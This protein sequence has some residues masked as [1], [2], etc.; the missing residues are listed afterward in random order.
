MTE[1][2]FALREFCEVYSLKTLIGF[3]RE[4]GLKFH[5]NVLALPV[6]SDFDH[7]SLETTFSDI[8][9]VNVVKW[10]DEAYLSR[11]RPYGFT[12]DKCHEWDG[13]MRMQFSS[14]EIASCKLHSRRA[15]SHSDGPL[16][17]A[18]N[19]KVESPV[20][21]FQVGI[22]GRLASLPYEVIVVPRHPL[23]SQAMENVVIPDSIRFVNTMGELE[24]L[25]AEAD[26]TIM[27]RILS[28]DGLR[29]D[30]D[31]NP[32][33]ATINSNTLCGVISEIP[34]PYE[35]LYGDSG[36][37]HQ[38]ST[39]NSMY[40]GINRWIR[41][42]D[43]QVKLFRRDEWVRSNRKRYLRRIIEVLETRSGE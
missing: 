23:S 26:L 39:L 43:L 12:T 29:P 10:F 25:H 31:H 1:I 33:E 36:L 28:R 3:C 15:R 8:P 20:E 27:G 35:W 7:C 37:I 17:V 5:L 11:S 30:D 41:D 24:S 2:T 4:L 13:Y 21:D 34:A 6:N 32:I 40:E 38:Y 14:Q 42:P 22:F 19:V 16:V 18:G 9:E